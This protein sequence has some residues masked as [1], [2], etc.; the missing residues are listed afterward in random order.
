[1][2]AT[3]QALFDLVARPANHPVIDGS[4]S[5]RELLP[6]SP[7]RLELGATFSM[8]MHIVLGYKIRNTVV[9]F[10]EGRQI[11]W[12]HFYGHRWRYL[13][14]PAGAATLVTEQWDARPAKSRLMLSLLGFPARNRVGMLASLQR[15]EELAAQS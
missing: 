14:E 10:E 7:E 11:A 13:F 15:L 4:G 3:A 5:V 9:E 2:P 12:Q 8:D 6:G 1:M